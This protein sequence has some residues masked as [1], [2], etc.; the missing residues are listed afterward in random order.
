[1]AKKP[2]EIQGSNLSLGGI[3]LQAGTTGVVIPGIT[4]AANYIVEEVNDTGVDQN[5]Q[6][7]QLSIV[8]DAVTYTA[9]STSASIAGY[10]T[11]TVEVDDDFYIDEIEVGSPGSYT[12]QEKTI[13]ETTNI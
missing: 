5:V 12:Q 9:L 6:F 3:N 4:Q 13:N 7:T 2:F 11:Y 1:M 8:I 10:A